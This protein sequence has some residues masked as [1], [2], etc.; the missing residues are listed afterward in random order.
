MSQGSYWFHFLAQCLESSMVDWQ[1]VWSLN[2]NYLASITVLL[3]LHLFFLAYFK[4]FGSASLDLPEAS[5]PSKTPVS[6]PPH[7]GSSWIDVHASLHLSV[8][9]PLLLLVSFFFLPCCSLLPHSSPLLSHSASP[10][11]FPFLFSISPLLISLS[12]LCHM[13]LHI[14]TEVLPTQTLFL[15]SPL[16]IWLPRWVATGQLPEEKAGMK[17]G[18]RARLRICWVSRMRGVVLRIPWLCI[19]LYP[20]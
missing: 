1:R 3:F 14:C 7:L 6:L 17:T 10:C 16:P 2:F 15:H 4:I 9:W 12:I 8:P 18:R 20:F 19:P 11:C 5:L 13:V